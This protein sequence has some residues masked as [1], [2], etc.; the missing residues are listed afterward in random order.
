MG[1]RGATRFIA[2]W[3]SAGIIGILVWTPLADFYSAYL[4]EA[5]EGSLTADWRNKLRELGIDRGCNAIVEHLTVLRSEKDRIARELSAMLRRH[6]YHLGLLGVDF[7]EIPH[8]IELWHGPIQDV[9]GMMPFIVSGP[10]S[11]RDRLMNPSTHALSKAVG[12]TE[13]LVKAK[14]EEIAQKRREIKTA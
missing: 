11:G 12:E 1:V 10:P 14:R 6:S 13:N 8:R 3:V 5:G 4:A 9:I 2:G 7:G